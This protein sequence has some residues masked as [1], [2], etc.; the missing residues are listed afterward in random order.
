MSE[1]MDKLDEQ[2]YA[3]VMS[4]NGTNPFM[5]KIYEYQMKGVEFAEVSTLKEYAICTNKNDNQHESDP[6]MYYSMV[7]DGSKIRYFKLS[8]RNAD[9]HGNDAEEITEEDFL[10]KVIPFE[11]N[12]NLDIRDTG[13]SKANELTDVI[14][15]VDDK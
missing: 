10:A 8:H 6:L 2:V 12:A 15:N 4:F 3:K 1:L 9:W 7:M 5:E 14:K 11:T 13:V